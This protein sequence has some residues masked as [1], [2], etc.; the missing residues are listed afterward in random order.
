MGSLYLNIV[1]LC[2]PCVFYKYKL[3]NLFKNQK[4]HSLSQGEV[5]HIINYFSY[6]LIT[7]LNKEREQISAARYSSDRSSII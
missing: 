3:V 7:D 6:Q 4:K 2:R 5:L 1:C